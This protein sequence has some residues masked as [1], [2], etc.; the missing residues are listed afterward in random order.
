VKVKQ[1]VWKMASL[2]EVDTVDAA[3]RYVGSYL[4]IQSYRVRNIL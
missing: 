2:A 4:N 3:A 1:H